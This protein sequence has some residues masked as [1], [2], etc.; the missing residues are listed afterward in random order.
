MYISVQLI[1]SMTGCFGTFRPGTVCLWGQL[2]PKLERKGV[3]SYVFTTVVRPSP[4][5][6]WAKDSGAR[7]GLEPGTVC[8]CQLFDH[9]NWT[10]R[11]QTKAFSKTVTT[12]SISTERRDRMLCT[13]KLKWLGWRRLCDLFRGT[14]PEYCWT[15]PARRLKCTGC[16]S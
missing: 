5:T 14:V 9:F 12:D 8:L 4:R 7:S 16:R 3:Q 2:C 6:V 10:A 11:S 1:C 15:Q 13:V